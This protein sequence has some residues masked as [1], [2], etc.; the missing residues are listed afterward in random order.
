M[1]KRSKIH[2][3]LTLAARVILSLTKI[4]IITSYDE[5]RKNRA[6]FKG[7]FHDHPRL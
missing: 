1:E 7:F 6:Y 4:L 2:S 3:L 5:F